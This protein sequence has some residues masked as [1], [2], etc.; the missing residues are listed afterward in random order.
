MN[1]Q[2]GRIDPGCPWPAPFGHSLS[3]A[4]RPERRRTQ[5]DCPTPEQRFGK[6]A[7][8]RQ[9]WGLCPQT[10]RIC[11]LRPIRRC[12]QGKKT[13]PYAASRLLPPCSAPP[14]RSGR[15]P[16]SPYPPGGST[17]V[18]HT[19]SG[20]GAGRTKNRR[21][22]HRARRLRRRPGDGQLPRTRSI[23][24]ANPLTTPPRPD[25]SIVAAT[26]HFYFA[27]TRVS[28]CARIHPESLPRSPIVAPSAILPDAVAVAARACAG[29]SCFPCARP[30]RA[31][32][33]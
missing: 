11:R 15:F 1:E 4:P 23:P 30:A 20:H 8:L 28:I 29:V 33:V 22:S 16:A 6:T 17:P 5:I 18:Y 32:S 13:R 27:L 3:G 9:P 26:G 21:L 2:A 25:I 7:S 14:R 31:R 24:L 12:K 19:R 10:P